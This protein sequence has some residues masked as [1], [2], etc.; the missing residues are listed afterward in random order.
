MINY[1]QLTISLSL[2]LSLAACT[3]LQPVNLTTGELQR[4]LFAGKVIQAD[5]K[6]QLTTTNGI[7]HQFIVTEITETHIKGGG[8][9]VPVN[10]VSSVTKMVRSYAKTIALGVGIVSAGLAATAVIAVTALAH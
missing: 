9:S 2:A 7:S 5:D 8:K 4:Q 6:I 10:T 1:K 3:T